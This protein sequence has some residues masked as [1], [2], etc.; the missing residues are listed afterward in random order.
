MLDRDDSEADAAFAWEHPASQHASV[1]LRR[2]MEHARSFSE[3]M[4][5]AAILYNLYLS[6][7]EPRRDSVID[8]CEAR[9]QDWVSSIGD[10][11]PSLTVG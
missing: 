4:N 7:L 9:L 6:E 5:G 8:D 2:E 3:V 11:A 10:T 1:E